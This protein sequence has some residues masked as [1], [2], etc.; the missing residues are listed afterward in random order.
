[1]K[2]HLFVFAQIQVNNNNIRKY[3]I[4]YTNYISNNTTLLH[5]I[6]Y[7]NHSISN[8]LIVLQISHIMYTCIQNKYLIFL[9]FSELINNLH[10]VF[11]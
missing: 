4:I 9:L 8:L 5:L 10:D 6:V 2:N 3:I 11:A 7:I 1:M